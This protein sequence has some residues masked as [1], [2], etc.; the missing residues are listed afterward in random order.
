MIHAAPTPAFAESVRLLLA[1]HELF[2]AGEDQS[3]SAD[4]VRAAM[5]PSWYDMTEDEQGAIDQLSADLYTLGDRGVAPR[6]AD[7]V[8]AAFDRARADSDL[9]TLLVLLQDH[10]GLAPPAERA[11]LRAEAW[12]ALG[13]PSAAALF[14]EDARRAEAPAVLRRR[15]HHRFPHLA[16][17]A[18]PVAM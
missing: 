2:V 11:R 1:L 17:R 16:M 4:L 12:A 14:L 18:A 7:E 10:P 9:A 5:E 3:P 8:S 6:P 13:V 15:A